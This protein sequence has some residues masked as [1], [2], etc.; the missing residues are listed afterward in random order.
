MTS[1]DVRAAT[2]DALVERESLVESVRRFPNGGIVLV[3]LSLLVAV[4]TRWGTEQPVLAYGLVG[5]YFGN[6]LLRWMLRRRAEQLSSERLSAF[7]VALAL[8]PATLWGTL[9]ASTIL[10]L[11]LGADTLLVIILTAG[12]AA[13]GHSSLALLRRTHLTFLLVLALPAATAAFARGG[14]IAIAMGTSFLI[15]GLYLA[16][17]GHRVAQRSLRARRRSFSR[18]SA[19]SSARR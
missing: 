8:V 12:I 4:A 2:I 11:G 18:W 16:R 10:W 1:P 3:L 7:L 19:T 9:A 14:P 6:A 5:L 17:D 15:F 13:G